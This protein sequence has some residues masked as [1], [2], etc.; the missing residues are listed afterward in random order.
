[1]LAGRAAGRA[2]TACPA[3]GTT[4][5]RG[6]MLLSRPAGPTLRT[7]KVPCSPRNPRLR[8]QTLSAP[9]SAKAA[10]S[11]QRVTDRLCVLCAAFSGARSSRLGFTRLAKITGEEKLRELLSYL[12]CQAQSILKRKRPVS[13]SVRTKSIPFKYF[14]VPVN[15]FAYKGLIYYIFELVG[16]REGMH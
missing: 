15:S 2:G 1:M 16:K 12:K 10:P 6:Q 3:L 11:H 14:F 13:Q 7:E 8:W 9:H 5:T 4:A